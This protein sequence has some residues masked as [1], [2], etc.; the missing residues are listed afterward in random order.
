MTTMTTLNANYTLAD[1]LA[2]ERPGTDGHPDWLT[3]IQSAAATAAL[4]SGLPSLRDEAWRFSSLRDLTGMQFALQPTTQQLLLTDDR[5]ALGK[6]TCPRLVFVDGVY[7]DARSS[8][9]DLPAGVTIRRMA[10]A[11]TADEAV[12]RAGFNT[13]AEAH[14]T[15]FA[16][17][18]TARCDDVVVVRVAEG[19]QS[20]T[21]VLIQHV[22]TSGEPIATHPR[23]LIVAEKNT[24][25]T[26]VE[27]Y[28][29]LTKA[30]Y[31]T[32]ALTEVHVADDAVLEH[33][34]L[35]RESAA[36]V[37]ISTLKVRQGATSRFGSHSLL[38]EGSFVRNDVHPI[39]AGEHC[40]SMLNGLYVGRNSQHFD[41]YMRV[42]H[43]MPN[44]DSRQ[45][46]R[47]ILSDEAHGVFGGRIV[48]ARDAQKTDAVQSNQNLLLS[49]D[50]RANA[51]P[52][53]EIYADDVKCT[54]GAT[55]GELD[56]D[57][58]FYLRSRGMTEQAAQG[59][60]I[61]SFALEN[62]D[63][64]EHDALRDVFGKLLID[65]LPFT[66]SLRGVL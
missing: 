53:L 39:L 46:Y 41:N 65:R 17:L 13:L 59:M 21:P 35:V 9:A 66:E 44:C 38:L 1:L 31:F 63:R 6:L 28:L 18:N 61:Y 43:A 27:D 33:Y 55:I 49:D 25:F 45:Y 56:S 7:D 20:D 32:N 58:I 8:L 26:V 57:A 42:E 36:A 64:M 3:A 2:A 54:H 19:V 37:N 52:Q 11:L 48:V 40:F 23:T 5:L 24:K 15:V 14:S 47:G 16:A 4:E 50:A 62:L 29:G 12:F 30:A 51:M 34:M 60:L 22:T 10:D